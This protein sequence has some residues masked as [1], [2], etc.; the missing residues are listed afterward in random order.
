VSLVSFIVLFLFTLERLWDLKEMTITEPL[1]WIYVK[2]DIGVVIPEM[3]RGFSLKKSTAIEGIPLG[4][5]N[6]SPK[7]LLYSTL[8]MLNDFLL[9]NDKENVRIVRDELAIA[10]AS[11]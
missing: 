4:V 10:Y 8:I 1:C 9:T 11:K 3:I 6:E 2:D 7:E 5:S